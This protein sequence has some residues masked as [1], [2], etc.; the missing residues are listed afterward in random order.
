[1]GLAG[2]L[3]AYAY[4][5]NKPLGFVDPLGLVLFAFGSLA[6][7]MPSTRPV[8]AMSACE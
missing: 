7:A 8:T 5:G 4:V 2:G 3:N 1:M 6:T